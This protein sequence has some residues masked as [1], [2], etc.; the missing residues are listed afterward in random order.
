MNAPTLND[1]R[2]VFPAR[3][4]A[5][6]KMNQVRDLLVGDF[7]REM[8][9]RTLAVENRMSAMETRLRDLENG[10]GQR[11]TELHGRIE[12]MSADHTLDRNAAFRELAGS[13]LELSDKIRAISRV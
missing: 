11:L 1:L 3:D 6:E 13:V 4:L 10:L 8:Q 12:Q 2:N 9:A 5:D 7:V